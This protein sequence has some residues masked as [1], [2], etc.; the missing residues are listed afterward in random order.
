MRPTPLTFS[1]ILH[2]ADAFHRRHRRWPTSR[3]GPIPSTA[4]ATWRR[5]DT[6][7]RLGLRGL[8]GGSSL[9]QLLA[10]ERGVRKHAYQPSLTVP[11]ILS[12]A[13][14]YRRRTGRWP[15]IDSGPIDQAPGETWRRIDNACAWVCASCRVGLL[16]PS[17][18][19][20]GVARATTAGFAA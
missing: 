2:W 11:Q 18:S 9:P 15:T 14:S 4:D 17:C 7:L 5:V 8:P 3:D 6:A 19:L 12:W 10:D 13:D 20:G 1:Q 16:W